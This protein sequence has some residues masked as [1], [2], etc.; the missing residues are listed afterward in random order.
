MK[1]ILAGPIQAQGKL[2]FEKKDALVARAR[3]RPKNHIRDVRKTSL[4]QPGLWAAVLICLLIFR[5]QRQGNR[6]TKAD[7]PQ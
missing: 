3:Y 5:V 4:C 2:Q 7:G 6:T 1:T